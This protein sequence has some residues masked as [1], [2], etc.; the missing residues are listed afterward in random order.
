MLSFFL[1]LL[2]LLVLLVV[3]HRDK[4]GVGQGGGYRLIHDRQDDAYIIKGEKI[5]VAP[6]IVESHKKGNFIA[7]LRLP[8][9]LLSC[10]DSSY[11]TIRVL[12]QRRYFVLDILNEE[13]LS[14]DTQKEFEEKLSTLG[15]F[16][17]ASFDYSRFDS[18]WNKYSKLY[19]VDGD[20]SNCK[21]F[22]VGTIE[23]EKSEIK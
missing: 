13:L 1:I 22:P 10:D 2:V 18:V 9:R 23:Y 8:I 19:Q 14:F 16:D 3:W 7:G 15:G 20:I 11:S 6:T 17:L 21:D 12:N 5:I 4:P